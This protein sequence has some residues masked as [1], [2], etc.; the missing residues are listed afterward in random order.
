MRSS[1]RRP[2]CGSYKSPGLV[3]AVVRGDDTVVLGFGETAKG[4]KLEPN[5]RTMLRIGSISKAFAGELLASLAAEG[6][7]RLADPAAKILKQRC[8]ARGRRSADHPHRS[9]DAS[10]GLPR[11]LPGEAKPGTILTIA[12]RGR[13]T[14]L[15]SPRQSLPSR[16]AKPPPIPTSA[17]ICS[18]PRSRVRGN[19]LWRASQNPDYRPARHGRHRA[20]PRRGA[21]VTA[22]DRLRL[23][24]QS[25]GAVRGARGARRFRRHLFDRRRHGALHALAPEPQRRHGDPVRV[26]DH[27]LYLSETASRWRSASMK[28]ARRMRSGSLDEARGLAA[29]HL[30]EGRRVPGLHELCGARAEP[31]RRGLRRRE[32]FNFG[33]FSQLADTANGLIAELAPL[34]SACASLDKRIKRVPGATSFSPRRYGRSIDRLGPKPNRSLISVTRDVPQR[35]EDSHEAILPRVTPRIHAPDE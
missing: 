7:L 34:S 12:S 20:S 22:D 1:S 17:S 11:D 21:E 14:K 13:T 32:S 19:R 10:A 18:A 30:A 29:L 8:P 24:R 27:A 4:S 33:A 5:G 6:K 3:L 9:R 25:D 2:R 16:P 31:R 28:R 23:R 15:I 26:I 35:D